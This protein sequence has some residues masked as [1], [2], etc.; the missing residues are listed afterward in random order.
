MV[1]MR[2]K[3]PCTNLAVLSGFSGFGQKA[4]RDVTLSV[5]GPR[6]PV[7]LALNKELRGGNKNVLQIIVGMFSNF[8]PPT[9]TPPSQYTCVCVYM[10]IYFCCC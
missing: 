5:A 1:R 2:N 8:C 7:A 6:L 4:K 10:W 9:P 3:L